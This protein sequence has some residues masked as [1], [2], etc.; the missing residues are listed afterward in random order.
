MI[1]NLKIIEFNLNY[2]KKCDTLSFP[3]AV[4]I[5]I[6]EKENYLRTSIDDWMEYS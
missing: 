2:N 4:S 3:V 6:E 5:R 1:N